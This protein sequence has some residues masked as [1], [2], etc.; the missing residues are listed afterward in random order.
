MSF[1]TL[2][3]N[4]NIF[5]PANLGIQHIL[6]AGAKIAAISPS[7]SAPIGCAC[8]T[9][10]LQGCILTPGFIDSHVHL[11]G[12]GGEGGF[13]TRTPELNLSQITAAGV[14]TV[15]GCLGA[16][17]LT[18]HVDS[19]LAK[20]SS[21][22]QEGISSFIYTGCYQLPPPTIT[23]SICKDIV[24]I[25]KIIG[26][27]EIAMSDH[28]SSQSTEDDYRKL[29]AEARI[30]GL[31]SG[32]AGIIDLHLG[33][34]SDGLKKLFAITS[35]N[36]IPKTQ[37]LPTH[38]NRS[39]RLF[40]ESLR[41]AEQGGFIDLTSDISPARNAPQS[42]KPSLAARI[43]LDAGV[44]LSRITM[45]SDANGSTPLFDSGGNMIGTGIASQASLLEE[46]KDMIRTENINLYDAIQIV[47]TNV[48]KALKLWP[49]K[50]CITIGS[51]ADFAVFDQDFNLVHVF[52]KGR[53]LRKDGEA[54]VFG[55]F[56]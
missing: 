30:S 47:T 48:A 2:L 9:V 43:A 4:A 36:E 40:E 46:I 51:D 13:T 17:G 42:I 3:K 10:D 12:G 20:A 37:F 24:M 26:I 27:G 38:V 7:V 8:T 31:L 35:D 45:S 6:I 28:R 18:R 16:D 32:K 29:A 14:T 19:L 25:D 41:W 54:I 23:G 50:G 49:N 52:A 55:T 53:Q 44:P 34:G 11:I 15:V 5:S 1:F 21:L 56:E 33:D 39:S 22:E